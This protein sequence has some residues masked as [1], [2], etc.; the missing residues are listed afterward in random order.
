MSSNNNIDETNL[1][2]RTAP[3]VRKTLRVAFPAALVL[4]VALIMLAIL[5]RDELGGIIAAFIGVAVFCFAFVRRDAPMPLSPLPEGP[6]GYAYC[7]E[8][9]AQSTN[10]VEKAHAFLGTVFGTLRTVPVLVY[11]GLINMHVLVL[12]ATGRNKTFR[13][14]IPLCMQLLRMGKSSLVYIDLKGETAAFWI[15]AFCARSLG[16]PVYYFS[17][18]PNEAS[19]LMNL[20]TDPAFLALSDNK[21]AQILAQALGLEAGEAF[22]A[23][24]FSAM[25]EMFLKRSLRVFRLLGRPLSFLGLHL[26]A[27]DRSA[28]KAIGMSRRDF[29]NASHGPAAMEKLS[30]DPRLN[31]TGQEPINPALFANAITIDKILASPCLVFLKLSALDEATS[32]RMLARLFIRI[33]LARAL[34]WKGPRVETVYF[35]LDEVQEILERSLLGAPIK[36][37]R[38]LGIS[39]LFSMQNLSDLKRDGFDFI[40][41]MLANTAVK[42]IMSAKDTAGREY[43]IDSS[44]ETVM[45]LS[46]SSTTRTE[47][48]TGESVSEGEQSHDV[49]V[50]RIDKEQV[51]L[52]NAHSELAVF[53]ATPMMG[54]TRL[55]RPTT[56]IEIPF[57]MTEDEFKVFDSYEWPDADGVMSVLAKDLPGP[58][59]PELGA[60]EPSPNPQSPSQPGAK[61]RRKPKP[62]DPE[63]E[64]RS[65][66][67]AEKLKQLGA[68]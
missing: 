64:A 26:F 14:L 59:P 58:P 12:G 67:I 17:L 39:F 53:E 37:A 46:S 4:G 21:R 10:A 54:F 6:A 27:S 23:G 56:I 40:D 48:P 16:I 7:T 57:P 2:Y 63:E 28:R 49:V 38:S 34:A 44:G 50:P 22:G 65:V 68:K 25:I 18:N 45:K 42:V 60:P 29:E 55:E 15:L 9:L 51:S 8:L 61:R 31:M 20:L 1:A 30:E 13:V 19:C 66:K 3:P 32:A 36:Q 52:L 41:T 11:R 62:I 43:L 24:F 33:T 5:A 35:A 47:S